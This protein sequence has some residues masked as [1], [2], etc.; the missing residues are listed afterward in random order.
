MRWLLLRWAINA[1]ALFVT[2]Q[3]IPGITFTGTLGNLVALA[4]IF[5]IL[6]ALLRP[7]LLLLSCPLIVLTLGAFALAINGILLWFTASV[8]DRFDLGLALSG[9][10]SAFF[11]GLMMG[12][13]SLLAGLLVRPPE[14]PD[15]ED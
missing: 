11:G 8:A 6:N 12:F 2:V 3:L 14:A 5:G 13:V 10:W 9:P 4:A 15:E 7:L 1:L